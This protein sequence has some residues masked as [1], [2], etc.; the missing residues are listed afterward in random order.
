MVAGELFAVE[1]DA[2]VFDVAGWFGNYIPYKYDLA[3]FIAVNSVTRDHLVSASPLL[4]AAPSASAYVVLRVLC[5]VCC[6]LQDPSIFTVLTCA[7]AE[8]G[9]A[10]IDFVIFPPRWAVQ[11]STFRPPYYHKNCM[12]EFMGNIR[13][14]YEAKPEGFLPGGGSLHR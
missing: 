10:C 11:E 6:A 2:S 14:R 5:A 9:V 12:T 1:T 7:T 3:H 4:S 13:G 8:A